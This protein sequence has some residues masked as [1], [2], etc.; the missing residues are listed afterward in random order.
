MKRSFSIRSGGN[1]RRR[2]VRENSAWPAS[3][4]DDTR[5][6]EGWNGKREGMWVHCARR[7]RRGC[8]SCMHGAQNDDILV[9]SS[10]ANY[11]SNL[12]IYRREGSGTVIPTIKKLMSHGI[13]SENFKHSM[14]IHWLSSGISSFLIFLN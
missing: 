3:K 11:V 12:P 14:V 9:S 5:I 1:G 8:I 13:S 6:Y 2:S 10:F 7:V 4:I